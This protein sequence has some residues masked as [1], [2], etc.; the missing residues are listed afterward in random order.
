MEIKR[1]DDHEAVVRLIVKNGTRAPIRLFLW[2]WGES[3][4][5]GVGGAFEVS[6][7]GAVAGTLVTEQV[8][9]GIVV[10]GWPGCAISLAPVGRFMVPVLDD[11]ADLPR[12]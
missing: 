6:A 9:G 10:S 3:C 4:E 5:I 1:T 8:E 12:R 2:P 7:R 11:E